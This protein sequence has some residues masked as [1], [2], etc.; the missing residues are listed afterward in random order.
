MCGIVGIADSGGSRG[1]GVEGV[2]RM[3]DA[4]V[5]RGPDDEGFY[6]G[7]D[8]IL[9]MRRLSII[10][11]EGGHQPIPNSD[12]SVWVVNNGEIY[13]FRELRD[14]LKRSGYTF[15]TESDT[16]VIVHAYDAYG[17]AFL[18]HLDGMFGLAL[19]DSRS[20]TLIVA[21]DRL[22][23]KPVYYVKT[24]R[25]LAFAS[26]V[27]SLLQLPGVTAQ[28]DQEALFDYT[29]VGYAVAP[30]TI[31][32]GVR[33]LE[34]GTAL[35]WSGGDIAIRR[36]WSPPT[37]V[38]DSTDYAAWQEKV[39]EG[40]RGAVRSHMV[41]DVPV[42]AF[43]SGGIDSSAVVALMAEST[44][45]AINTYSIGYRGSDVA[46]YYNELPYAKTVAETIGT[47]HREIEVQPDVAG[48]LPKLIWHLEEPISDSAITTTYLVSELA[49]RSNKVIQSGVGG[50][51]LFAGYTR[52]LG[53]HYSNK[54]RRIPGWARR[55]VLARLAHLLPSGRQN[56]LMDLSR[57]AKRFIQPSSPA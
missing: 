18:E 14:R 52:Y 11:L 25:F 31:F 22:G 23:M 2:R 1:Y 46:D 53:D 41:A 29:T 57:Y 4:I 16:E 51:E 15:R 40:L 8:V 44:D 33:K 12:R 47:N 20:R 34:P 56:R 32:E 28:V 45:Q 30:R 10:D 42:G 19:W 7:G 36:Y 50:D 3:A 21:R 35:T 27:K 38:D 54:Y 49:A 26:E 5:H 43:L 24:G 39:L 9:G 6:D 17:S 37:D 55:Q 13:N 48:L